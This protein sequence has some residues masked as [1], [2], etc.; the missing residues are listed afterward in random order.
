MMWNNLFINLKIISCHEECEKN[1]QKLSIKSI[2]LCQIFINEIY[3]IEIEMGMKMKMMVK[4]TGMNS[5][6]VYIW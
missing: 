5:P 2:G 1:E 3:Q 4:D 6:R